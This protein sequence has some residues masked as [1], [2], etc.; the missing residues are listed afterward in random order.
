MIRRVAETAPINIKE[1]QEPDDSIANI[2]IRR[3]K[4]EITVLFVIG[5]LLA[6]I[7]FITF[8]FMFT[9]E[10]NGWDITDFLIP[11]GFFGPLIYFYRS[12]ERIK[13]LRRYSSR[14]SQRQF[15]YCFSPVMGRKLV[16][17]IEGE[18]LVFDK[19]DMISQ[20]SPAMSI[21][22]RVNQDILINKAHAVSVIILTVSICVSSTAYE[23]GVITREFYGSILMMPMEIIITVLV[24]SALL[25][26]IKNSDIRYATY[27]LW[28]W[29]HVEGFGSLFLQFSENNAL[30]L[31]VSVVLLALMGFVLWYINKDLIKL[32]KSLRN[33]EFRYCHATVMKKIGASNR[34][35]IFP[36]AFGFLTVVVEDQN[37]NTYTVKMKSSIYNSTSEGDIGTLITL[38]EDDRMRIFIC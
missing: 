5:G 35:R 38:D 8:Y 29:I 11:I 10:V 27:L 12:S 31:I 4:S 32:C 3:C 2:I 9:N 26:I 18:T 14:A 16:V 20:S 17:L 6:I 28:L 25:M 37:G 7:L 33:E 30:K 22:T 21:E 13:I 34:E 1:Y 23:C 15:K 19:V 36:V 24:L